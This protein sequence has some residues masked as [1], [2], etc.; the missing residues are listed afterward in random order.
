MPGVYRALPLI[1]GSPY[2]KK[3]YEGARVSAQRSCLSQLPNSGTKDKRQFRASRLAAWCCKLI[4][5]P[6]SCQCEWQIAD[7]V[8]Q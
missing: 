2:Y 1:A 6:T 4:Q 7:L 5:K 8:V 3:A